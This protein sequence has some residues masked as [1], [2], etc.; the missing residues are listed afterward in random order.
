[1]A[2]PSVLRAFTV[3]IALRLSQDTLLAD[4]P[5]GSI[6]GAAV[7]SY[8]CGLPV[9]ESGWSV[10]AGGLRH[11]QARPFTAELAPA[12]VSLGEGLLYYSAQPSIA[13]AGLSPA[14]WSKVEGCT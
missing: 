8:C 1:M 6:F 11:R 9:G 13:E 4:F 2:H 3:P 12:E 5:G 10:P 14:G 7:F